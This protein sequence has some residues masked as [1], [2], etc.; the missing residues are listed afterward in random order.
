MIIE[1]VPNFSEGRRPG[2]VDQIAAVVRAAPGVSLLDLQADKDHNRSVLTFV[3][4]PSGL[5]IAAVAAVKKAMELIDLTKHQGTHPRMGACDVLPFVPIRDASL[6]DCVQM[7]R[8]VGQS[9]GNLGIPVFLYEAAAT[10]PERKNLADIRNHHQ[11]EGLRE[12]IGSD[13]AF[14]P[15]SG[16]KKIHPTAGATAVGARMPLIAYNIDLETEDLAIAKAIA[17]K[18]REKGG[19]LPG[20]KALGMHIAERKC[21]QVSMNVCDYTRTSLQKVYREV[22]RLAGESKVKIRSSEVVGMLPAAALSEDW[23]RELKLEAFTAG[24]IIENRI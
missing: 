16:P 9:V 10:R 18:I 11:F 21:A 3:G 5:K 17:K 4:T 22:E 23:I 7:A 2:V 24:Q 14:D 15:D 8:E 19:G 20:I 6:G 13:P 12:R 1:C